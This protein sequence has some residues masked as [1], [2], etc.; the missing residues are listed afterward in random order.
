MAD[1]S[2]ASSDAHGAPTLLYY[3]YYQ[4]F[5]SIGYL[6]RLTMCGGGG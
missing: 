1:S 2:G 4:R 6:N 5:I 3:A